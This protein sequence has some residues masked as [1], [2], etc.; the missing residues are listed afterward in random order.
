MTRSINTGQGIVTFSPTKGSKIFVLPC[1]SEG[2][3]DWA[4]SPQPEKHRKTF[5]FGDVWSA[6]TSTHISRA[7][8]QPARNKKM[9]VVSKDRLT[10]TSLTILVFHR[11][12]SLCI[13][14]PTAFAVSAPVYSPKPTHNRKTTQI[15]A[16]R[17]LGLLY[18]LHKSWKQIYKYWKVTI[19]GSSNIDQ[20][21]QY[22]DP[23]KN[24]EPRCRNPTNHIF[25]AFHGIKCEVVNMTALNCQMSPWEK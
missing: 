14:D 19:N 1:L 21:E 22:H 8:W 6:S 18:T 3:Q 5:L 7:S 10:N 13:H 15:V 24:L 9:K 25:P 20:R 12:P 17:F 2:V 4:S 23:K 11:S 16:L